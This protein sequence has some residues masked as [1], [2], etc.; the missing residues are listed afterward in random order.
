MYKLF[1]GLKRHG[2][3]LHSGGA[4]FTPDKSTVILGAT[5]SSA[6]AAQQSEQSKRKI[7]FVSDTPPWRRCTKYPKYAI[8]KQDSGAARS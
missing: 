4:I 5:S 7:I 8:Q 2:R 6:I 1:V 3:P